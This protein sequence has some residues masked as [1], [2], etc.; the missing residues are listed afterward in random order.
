MNVN[1]KIEGSEDVTRAIKKL[2]A[3]SPLATKRAVTQAALLVERG[4]KQR[5][6]VD[7]G[8]LRSSITYELT[9]AKGGDVN[10]AIVGTNVEYAPHQEFG[11]SRMK[12]HPYLIPALRESITRIVAFFEAELKKL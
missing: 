4:A 3:A 2:R 10:G 6:P 8:R 7:T 5:A 11:T 9:E 12:A 1:V